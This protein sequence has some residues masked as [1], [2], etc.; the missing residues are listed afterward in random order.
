MRNR[1]AK[2]QTKEIFSNG[3]RKKDMDKDGWLK[4]QY[5]HPSKECLEKMYQQPGL[6][7]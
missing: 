1:E 7:T 2:F 3:K 4:K 5:F 6:K